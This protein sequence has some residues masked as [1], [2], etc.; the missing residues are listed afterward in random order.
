MAELK[1]RPKRRFGIGEIIVTLIILASIVAIV[2]YA[3]SSSKKELT[4]NGYGELYEQLYG[5]EQEYV[6]DA[7]GEKI[8]VLDDEGN[9]VKDGDEI[10]Y[11][12]K[13]VWGLLSTNKKSISK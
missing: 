10:V 6:L 9:P 5:Y 4:L 13:D 8:P 11:Q 7:N 1:N 12:T 2:I 3:F